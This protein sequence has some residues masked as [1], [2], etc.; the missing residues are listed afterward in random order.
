MTDDEVT[1]VVEAIGEYYSTQSD[2]ITSA[3][4]PVAA[5]AAA[6]AEQEEI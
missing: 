2:R 4:K 1:F 3:S 5:V 6:A